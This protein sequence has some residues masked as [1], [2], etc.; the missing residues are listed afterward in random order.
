MNA[1]SGS[2]RHDNE[3]KRRDREAL[4]RHIGML[5]QASA[6]DDVRRICAESLWIENYANAKAQEQLEREELAALGRI[7]PVERC[8]AKQLR[9]AHETVKRLRI[10]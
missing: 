2:K 6:T 5:V 8:I 4:F 10:H 3:M 1:T 9:R 7:G